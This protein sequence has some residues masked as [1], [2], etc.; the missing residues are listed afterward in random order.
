M[1]MDGRVGEPVNKLGLKICPP[2]LGA[3][4]PQAAGLQWDWRG[5]LSSD[6]G[7]QLSSAQQEERGSALKSGVSLRALDR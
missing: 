6:P 5:S 1:G 4:S 2:I 7:R 3:H